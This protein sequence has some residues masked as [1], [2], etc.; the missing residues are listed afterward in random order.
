[1]SRVSIA[2][3]SRSL[4]SAWRRQWL[5]AAIAAIELGRHTVSADTYTYVGPTSGA[6]ADWDTPGNWSDTSNNGSPGIPG[7]VDADNAYIVGYSYFIGKTHLSYIPAVT[8]DTN[9]ELNGLTLDFSS[10]TESANSNL[11]SSYTTIGLNG[12][13][14]MYQSSGLAGF[15]GQLV[16]GL[17]SGSSG[18]YI[19]TGGTIE[20]NG[21]I[22]L[23]VQP[24]STGVYTFNGSGA[25]LNTQGSMYLGGSTGTSGGTGT[26]NVQS[27]VMTV[28][29]TL[30][31]WN[32][33]SVNLTGGTLNVGTLDSSVNNNGFWN[34]WTGGTLNIT[35]GELDTGTFLS[36]IANLPTSFTLNNALTLSAPGEN[37]GDFN[38]AT[39]NQTGGSNTVG[40]NGLYVGFG[41]G[42]SAY[43][44]SGGALVVA[45][46]EALGPG[47]NYGTIV[48]TGGSNATSSISVQGSSVYSLQ[49]GT[50]STGSISLES[51]TGIVQFNQTGGS[52]TITGTG[53]A[54]MIGGT[55]QSGEYLLN[56]G[57]LNVYNSV[58]IGNGSVSGDTAVL[59]VGTG[60]TMTV[61]GTLAVAN[62]PGS[63]IN[64]N[65]G[66]INTLALN[67]GATPGLFHW[68]TG[69]LN[70]ISGMTFDPAG[71][72]NE[73]AFGSSLNLISGQTMQASGI[74]ALGGVGPFALT[75][76]SGASNIV[77]GGVVVNAQGS[78]TLSGTYTFTTPSL[79]QNGGSISASNLNI[80]VSTSF[81][82]NGGTFTGAITNAGT[83]GVN[84][85]FT[86]GSISNMGVLALS[87]FGLTTSLSNFGTITGFGS[88]TTPVA[89]NYGLISQIGGILTINSTAS[90]DNYGTIDLQNGSQLQENGVNLSNDG[91]FNLSNGSIT[92]TS[93]LINKAD[94]EVFGPGIISTAFSNSGTLA[95]PN[96]TT[97]TGSFTNQGVIEMAGAGGVL[98]GSGTITNSATI[99]GYGK[100]AEAVVNNGTIQP[101]NGVLSF[102]APLTNSA[103][104]AIT[105]AT[106]SKVLMIGTSTFPSNAG[107]I[108]LAG[109]TFDN[110]GNPLNNTGQI[111]GYGILSTGGLTNNGTF[112]LTGGTTN[113]NGPVTNS[114]GKTLFVKNQPAIFS[115]AVI[116]NGTIKTTSTTVTFTGS[117]TGNAYVSDPSTN[118]FQNNV[119]IVPGGLM[120]GAAGDEYL[121]SG[122]TFTNNGTYANTGLLQ[123]SDPTVNSA[124][125]TQGGTQ[126]WA[127]GT[128][129]TNS[130]GA[131][132]FLTDA[133][134]TS[135]YN[136]AFNVAG[137]S[138]AVASP[139][140]WA[141]LTI[142]GSGTVDLANNH[143]IIA[144]A[145][146]D[147]GAA[148][149]Q[150][151]KTGY[152][153]GAWNGNGIDS[154]AAS[155]NPGYG[156]GFADGKDNVVAGLS[157]G[158]IEIA[159]TLY[160]DINLDGHVNGSDF[161]ILASHFGQTV[162]GGWEQGDLNYNGVVNGSDFAL[163][164]SN[165]GASA[166]GQAIALPAS[167]WAALDAFAAVHGLTADVPEPTTAISLALAT[168]FLVARRRSGGK[169]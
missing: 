23:G 112:V 155:T 81:S 97:R 107:L 127:A 9:P 56:G 137:G 162:T 24:G 26:L 7:S 5:L 40:G 37:I 55:D 133:G 126:T 61:D 125:F 60:G 105:A 34:N 148:I 45:G 88:I 117:Y 17:N 101:V 93:Q 168:G 161:A 13:A 76:G 64:L 86:I 113:V 58:S 102:A 136:L 68:T 124:S 53:N 159:Y 48:Q 52:N 87:G 122:G 31:L 41:N 91:T 167:D 164:A 67:D 69:T 109:G 10:L 99:E 134:S 98:A 25:T 20:A 103:T 12:A 11:Y 49:N 54:L 146:S 160:G 100:V 143:L 118:I 47:E 129:F 29:G 32:N 38:S 6:S 83:L 3:N 140:H 70:F 73:A 74:E 14:T 28:Q 71:P 150:Y 169:Q 19:Q 132:E 85:N 35:T 131:A 79:S 27:G 141:G 43:N 33:G 138:V 154:T 115:G 51:P 153:G 66:T 78:L 75:V 151:L 50:L 22:L 120:T 116:N 104:G 21:S 39:F 18:A 96:G 142:S 15:Y 147:P 16:I 36:P 57:T 30:K 4:S 165:F 89:D 72:S 65:G 8:L 84:S 110:G 94:G 163:L 156:L 80:P 90:N 95:V 46:T 1:M 62:T 135:G 59:T 130:A 119:T 166:S 128:T 108:S 114:A 144:Y 149:R 158:Q 123:S 152:N 111:D 106:G 139:Q 82:Y 77:T 92:G 44:L 145:S 2:K 42:G 157:S 121:M 63:A